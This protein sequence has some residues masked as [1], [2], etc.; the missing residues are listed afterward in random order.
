MIWRRYLPTDKMHAYRSS[1]SLT[2]LCNRADRISSTEAL[3][4]PEG[5]DGKECQTCWRIVRRRLAREEWVARNHKED[6]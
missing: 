3:F 5:K 2:S 4:I 6:L 1:I